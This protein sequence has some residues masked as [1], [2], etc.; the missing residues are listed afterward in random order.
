M[1][2]VLFILPSLRGGGAEKVIVHICRNLDRF[3]FEIVLAVL[4][5][6]GPLID[7]LPGDIRVIGMNISHARYSIIPIINLL[8]REVP[9]IVFSTLTH[10]NILMCFLKIFFTGFKLIIRE[11]NIVSVLLNSGLQKR[12]YKSS[13]P[14]ADLV[15]AQSMDMYNDLVRNFNCDV[16]KMQVINNFVDFDLIEKKMY[17]L[18]DLH[19]DHNRKMLL[20]VGRLEHQKGIDVLI[21][22]FSRLADKYI[23]QLVVL[24]TGS[25]RTALENLV[26]EKNLEKLVCFK[27]FVPNPYPYMHRA[28]FLISSSLFEGFPNVVI[29]AL[30]CGTPVIANLYPGGINEILNEE[31]GSIIDISDVLSFEAALS[32]KYDAQKIK[33]YCKG[34]YSM[35]NIIQQYEKI[36]SD[37]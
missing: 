18:P 27:G 33:E 37:I 19:F 36:L 2:K 26:H 3:H 14:K 22:T 21:N 7:S 6:Q 24:G 29:E 11:S 1:R 34:K 12:L 8:H 5:K 15:I 35:R 30:A 28:D 32:K 17:E 23:Y 9:D 13:I 25:L 16:K 31:V 4:L 10:I 20:F